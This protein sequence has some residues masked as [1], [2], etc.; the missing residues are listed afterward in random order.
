MTDRI[1]TLVKRISETRPV[2]TA[3]REALLSDLRA[4]R[5][6]I[7]EA[8][9]PEQVRSL[10][11]AL[12]L[13]EFMSRSQDVATAE[14]ISIVASLVGTVN[15]HL[16]RTPSAQPRPG[17]PSPLRALPN[18][19]V[20][21]H[22]DLRMTHEFLLGSVLLQ[23]G[24]ISPDSLSRALNLHTSSGMA[25]GQCLVQ[26]G[27]ASPEQIAGAVAYQD[28]LREEERSTRTEPE[29]PNRTEPER[30]PPKGDLRLTPK[31]K[32][33]VQ[34]VHTQVLGE[35]L[36]RLGSITREQ[37][38]RA[39]QLQRAANVHIGEALVETGAASWE[40]IKKALDVQRQLRRSAA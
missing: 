32:V 26:L 19:D 2:Q 3:R 20:A 40:Q 7:D 39:L 16:L 14:T 30:S 25:L 17:V 18:D 33:F 13:M 24:V 35:V 6:D 29:R 31:D 10:D 12:L 5:R 27:A 1:R 34:S 15:E 37:L 22:Q 21:Q 8:S 4:L 11:A 23:A 36:I 38:E 28:R 9:A